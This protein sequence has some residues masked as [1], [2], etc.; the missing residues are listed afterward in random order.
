VSKQSIALVAKDR[1]IDDA[2]HVA[3]IIHFCCGDVDLIAVA[4]GVV[5]GGT[6]DDTI[7]A[8]PECCAHAHGAGFAGG[9]EGV[10]G[11]GDCLE[12]PGGFANGADFSV[13]TGIELLLDGIEGAKQKLP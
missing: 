8:S 10:S 5:N 1:T 12:A 7:E 2:L 9:V 4:I 3:S 13:R 6:V 11:E